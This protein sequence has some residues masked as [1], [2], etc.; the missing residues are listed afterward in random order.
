MDS[1]LRERSDEEVLAL[2]V[3]D[4]AA[5]GV[6]LDRYQEPFLR[7]AF[8]VVKNEEDAEDV[9]QDAFMKIY[10]NAARFRVQAGATFKSWGYRILMNTAFTHYQKKKRARAATVELDPEFYEALPDRTDAFKKDEVADYLV[11]VFAKMPEHMSRALRLHFLE[12]RPQKEIADA[13]GISVGAVK[14]RIHRAKRE[15]KRI[16]GA[17]LPA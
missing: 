14:T 15:F 9:V 4:P 10:M 6:L 11:S 5:F 8:S 16:A 17:D 3:S 2:S 13:E 12:G 7:K 1:V